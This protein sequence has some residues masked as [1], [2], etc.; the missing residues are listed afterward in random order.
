MSATKIGLFVLASLLLVGEVFAE[1]A[2][3]PMHAA[4]SS[5]SQQQRDGALIVKRGV[6]LSQSVR[7]MLQT[8]RKAPAD[9]VKA[10][11][12]DGKL[13]QINAV[14]RIAEQ[15]LA[16][17]RRAV[18][19]GLRTHEFT[20]LTVLGQKFQVLGQEANQ[21]NGQ[22]MYETGVAKVVMVIDGESI[23][24][25]TTPSRPPAIPAPRLTTVPPS[26]SGKK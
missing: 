25:E 9:I 10:A 20:V 2:R 13:A 22:S 23:T 14:Q 11:C 26:A 1:A 12:L 18:D 5:T 21:C 17:L 15:R 24:F 19:S 16:S 7:T 3:P 4:P 8:A 6:A